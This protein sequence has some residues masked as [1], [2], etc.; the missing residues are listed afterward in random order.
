[1]HP[2]FQQQELFDCLKARN[3]LS[4]GYMPLGSP[5]RPERDILPDDIADMQQ[6][7]L[8]KIAEALI[9]H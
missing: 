5:R 6:P 7:E 9:T 4:V 3:I 8:L 2:C 1:M